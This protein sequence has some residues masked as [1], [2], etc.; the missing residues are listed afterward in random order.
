MNTPTVIFPSSNS[1]NSAEL[2]Y[3]GLKQGEATT[4][5]IDL[6]KYSKISKD[7]VYNLKIINY[8]KIP[9]N[10]EKLYEIFEKCK[11][12]NDFEKIDKELIQGVNKLLFLNNINF[13]NKNQIKK[14]DL[15]IGIGP[16]GGWLTQWKAAHTKFE[17]MVLG[18]EIINEQIEVYGAI[19]TADLIDGNSI[20]KEEVQKSIIDFFIRK[21]NMGCTYYIVVYKPEKIKSIF[22]THFEG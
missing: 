14:G 16:G 8:G 5:I 2:R 7:N 13:D 11:E 9:H 1:F 4:I 20:F 12:I 10:N 21:F 18:F 17:T 3:K 19:K 22:N 15:P 6:N